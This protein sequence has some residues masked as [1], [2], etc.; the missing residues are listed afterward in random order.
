MTETVRNRLE[1][2]EAGTF[3]SINASGNLAVTGA[4]EAASFEIASKATWKI[5]AVSL[6]AAELGGSETN[7]SFSFP[8]GG[9]ILIDAWLQ[10]TDAESGTVDVGTQG[11]SND[12]DGILDGASVATLGYVG[13]VAGALGALRGRFIT[14]ADPVSVTSSGDLNSCAATLFISYL[15]LPVIA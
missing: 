8:A 7:T 11:T 3:S 14:G 12:P 1:T 2:L 15:E 10:V 13:Q 5:A 6:G 4:A 9:A